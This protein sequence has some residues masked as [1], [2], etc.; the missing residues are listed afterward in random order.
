MGLGSARE[1]VLGNV[2]EAGEGAFVFESGGVRR[3]DRGRRKVT[4]IFR[5]SCLAVHEMFLTLRRP[6]GLRT[7]TLFGSKSRG[8]ILQ[9]HWEFLRY[10]KL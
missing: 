1:T 6:T 8:H 2:R 9:T 7:R 3:I 4:A 5:N 10:R